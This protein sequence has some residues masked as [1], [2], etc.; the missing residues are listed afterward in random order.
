MEGSPFPSRAG[1]DCQPDNLLSVRF[2]TK[3]CSDL[4]LQCQLSLATDITPEMLKTAMCRY[5]CKSLFAQ[6]TKNSP[7][8]RR[9]F[10]V[11]MWG[12]PHRLTENSRATSVTCLRLH[13]TA[14]VDPID[15][16][17]ENRH[18]AI[19]DFCNK[20]GQQQTCRDSAMLD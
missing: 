7:G 10:R 12:G 15:F 4:T 14:T 13:E 18:R 3:L 8:R 20:I 9:D 6:V 5:C 2:P 16:W 1:K 19:S 11:K 17:R